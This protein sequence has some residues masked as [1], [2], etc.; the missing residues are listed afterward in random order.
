MLIRPD[1]GYFHCEML[2][3][4]IKMASYIV[5]DVV[6]CNSNT[7]GKNIY[8]EEIEGLLQNISR[9]KRSHGI[10]KEPT[11]EDNKG[12][13]TKNSHTQHDKFIHIK[14]LLSIRLY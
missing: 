6:K 12:K 1:F 7:N 4:W 5:T 8:P 13:M 3:I 14:E 10:W 2:D 9:N 11:A